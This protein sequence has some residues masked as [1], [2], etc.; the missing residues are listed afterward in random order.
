MQHHMGVLP[1]DVGQGHF[2]E[3]A[4]VP[5]QPI[6]PFVVL[7]QSRLPVLA[8]VCSVQ[9]EGMEDDIVIRRSCFSL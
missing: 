3:V 7:N 4:R 8:V 1:D 9:A 6:L 2:G 5:G